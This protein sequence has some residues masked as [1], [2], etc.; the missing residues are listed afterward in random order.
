VIQIRI[1]HNVVAQ[2]E[3][4]IEMTAAAAAAAA[5]VTTEQTKNK[6]NNMVIIEGV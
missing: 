4:S 5:A 1:V 3:Q 6:V 2:F